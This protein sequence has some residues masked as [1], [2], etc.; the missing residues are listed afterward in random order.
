MTF[1]G[2][3]VVEVVRAGRAG[4]FLTSC[5]SCVSVSLSVDGVVPVEGGGERKDKYW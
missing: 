1:G 4:I 3:L 2:L 5:L